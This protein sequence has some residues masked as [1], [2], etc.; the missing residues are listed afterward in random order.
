ME[1]S[2]GFAK[3]HLQNIYSVFKLHFLK[4]YTP[5][6]VLRLT[7][8]CRILEYSGNDSVRFIMTDRF[9]LQ[10]RKREI[11]AGWMCFFLGKAGASAFEI[12]FSALREGGGESG[13][14]RNS[15]A[16]YS[17]F[18]KASKTGSFEIISK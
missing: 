5:N 15:L 10:E 7:R 6:H 11:I 2:A 4:N 1:K 3:Y 16:V 17:L 12:N 13:S 18:G 9:H 8:N 14:L